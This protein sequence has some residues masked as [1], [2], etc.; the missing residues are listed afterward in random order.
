MK[1]TVNKS[2]ADVAWDIAK[3]ARETRVVPYGMKDGYA[4]MKPS[5]VDGF[6][7]EWRKNEH[8]FGTG[9]WKALRKEFASWVETDPDSVHHG[10]PLP[11]DGIAV[12]DAGEFSVVLI[13]DVYDMGWW[14]WRWKPLAIV[15]AP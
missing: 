6:I 4:V 13:Q 1:I 8:P 5:D 3:A 12:L 9:A 2:R 10:Q 11:E 14:D 15:A 7:E